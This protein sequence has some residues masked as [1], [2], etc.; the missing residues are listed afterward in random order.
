MWL[1]ASLPA[2]LIPP[3]EKHLQHVAGGYAQSEVRDLPAI[4]RPHRLMIDV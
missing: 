1:L 4:P 2:D 3:V